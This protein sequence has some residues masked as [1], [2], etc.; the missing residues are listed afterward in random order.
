MKR[1]LAI[2]YT[3]KL[4]KKFGLDDWDVR[5]ND[6]FYYTLGQCKD[7]EKIIE[8]SQILVDNSEWLMVKETVL[9]EIAHALCPT[10]HYHTVTWKIVSKLIGC[11]EST[12]RTDTDVLGA[13]YK[14]A[15]KRKSRAK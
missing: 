8:I 7:K 9:H 14:K 12:S 1:S 15:V 3:R 11:N 4:L 2:A 5:L 10:D 6:R 13:D